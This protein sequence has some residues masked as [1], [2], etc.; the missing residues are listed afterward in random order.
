[1]SACVPNGKGRVGHVPGIET[2]MA[3]G[4]RGSDG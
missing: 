4:S 2:E 1:M 3:W